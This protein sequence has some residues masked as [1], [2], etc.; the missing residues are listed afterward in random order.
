MP[1]GL[2]FFRRR[3][4]STYVIFISDL[5]HLLFLFLIAGKWRIVTILAVKSHLQALVTRYFSIKFLAD[6]LGSIIVS[7]MDTSES[8][9]AFFFSPWPLINQYRNQYR[10]LNIALP[11]GGKQQSSWAPIFIF[12][13]FSWIITSEDSDSSFPLVAWVVIPSWESSYL[14][15]FQLTLK[16]FS[17]SMRR[18]EYSWMFTIFHSLQPW[19]TLNRRSEDGSTRSFLSIHDEQIIMFYYFLWLLHDLAVRLASLVFHNVLIAVEYYLVSWS[20]PSRACPLQTQEDACALD[21]IF[22]QLSDS[23]TALI[24]AATGR[25][26]NAAMMIIETPTIT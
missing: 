22:S 6:P 11:W 23:W 5:L 26:K 10:H 15:F 19:S 2:H 4:F 13:N 24:H 9:S 7:V 14:F 21:W 16:I 1:V 17:P 25:H 12:L 8:L 20:P 3:E 18:G